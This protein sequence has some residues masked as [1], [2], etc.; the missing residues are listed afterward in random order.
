MVNPH[1][2]VYVYRAE[3]RP[4]SKLRHQVRLQASRHQERG[5]SRSDW[6]SA[7]SWMGCVTCD[8]CV[9]PV[10][11]V[12]PETPQNTKVVAGADVRS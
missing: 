9:W 6:G 1:S 2:H 10:T 12:A 7:M 4:H 3:A 11:G 5:F 8:L